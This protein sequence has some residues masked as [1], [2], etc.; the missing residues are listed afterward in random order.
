MSKFAFKAEDY[1][2]G[3]KEYNPR[4]HFEQGMGSSLEAEQAA[5]LKKHLVGKGHKAYWES[6]PG[7]EDN[8]LYVKHPHD[9]D[10]FS[11]VTRANFDKTGKFSPKW[12]PGA[13]MMFGKSWDKL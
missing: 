13:S 2:S 3:G 9:P 4:N 5:A 8:F 1:T 11:S 6:G 10:Q 12:N 7:G